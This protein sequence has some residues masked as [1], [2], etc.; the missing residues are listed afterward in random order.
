V[1]PLLFFAVLAGAV[2]MFLWSAAKLVFVVG[3][4]IL[5]LLARPSRASIRRYGDAL[6]DAKF[7]P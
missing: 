2:W 5:R 6:R 4:S 3:W 1:L 7:R